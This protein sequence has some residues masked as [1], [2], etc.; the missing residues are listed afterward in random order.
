MDCN[1]NVS[2]ISGPRCRICLSDESPELIM[3]CNCAGTM[4]L[5]HA[6]CLEHWA[7]ISCRLCCEICKCKYRGQRQLKYGIIT[8]IIPFIRANWSFSRVLVFIQASIL[9]AIVNMEIGKYGFSVDDP[10]FPRPSSLFLLWAL[11]TFNLLVYYISFNIVS[12]LE[13]WNTWRRSQ[14]IFL[15]SRT[16]D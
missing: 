2:V 11:I 3:P 14:F 4:G 8:S 12:V 9:F 16:L 5:V 7:S 13:S 1:D 10:D 15:L 6:H